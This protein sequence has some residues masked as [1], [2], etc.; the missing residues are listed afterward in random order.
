MDYNT[1]DRE[2]SIETPFVSVK[3]DSGNH[4]IDIA[5]VLGIVCIL[6]IGKTV[7]KRIIDKI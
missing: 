7:I 6:W 1:E 5:S 3:S 2:F 4:F